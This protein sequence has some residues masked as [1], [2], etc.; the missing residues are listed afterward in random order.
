VHQSFRIAFILVAAAACIG[1]APAPAPSLSPADG[2][3]LIAALAASPGQGFK[4]DAFGQARAGQDSGALLDAAIAY[5]RAQHGL[6]LAADDFPPNWAIRPKGYDA[7]ADLS[8]AI[9]QGRVDAWASALPPQNP[10]YT[11]LVGAYG[12]YQALAARGGWPALAQTVKPGDTGPGVSALRA[13]LAVEDAAVAPGSDVYDNALADAIKR[14]QARHGLAEDGAA[15]PATLRALNV[16]AADRAGQIALNL[17][18]WRWMPRD[19]PAARAELN[20]AAAT[21]RSPRPAPR[22]SACG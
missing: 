4:V 10:G 9:A 2:Q 12:R 19:M 1:A 15:G 20:I 7:R 21:L 18:R 6:R 17:E 16:S 13:R 3:A 5:A 22:P 14:A 11:R 8:A